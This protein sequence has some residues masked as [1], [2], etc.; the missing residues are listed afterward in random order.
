MKGGQVHRV[1]LTDEMLAIL[2]P[3]RALASDY[4][5]EGQKR[6]HPL[7]NMSMLMLLRRMRQDGVTVHDRYQGKAVIRQNCF[8]GRFEPGAD[9]RFA[10]GNEGATKEHIPSDTTR[11]RKRP[12]LRFS[13]EPHLRPL[14]R[15]DRILM[16]AI[17]R[18]GSFRTWHLLA[19]L[20]AHDPTSTLHPASI[21][22]WRGHINRK[23]D[24]GD[25]HHYQV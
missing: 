3:L 9:L 1:P 10:V 8:D 15:S 24:V 21:R 2:E 4:V 6:H 7:S 25:W 22:Q 12:S 17:P 14:K 11:H 18:P 13:G 20:W 19:A 23:S 16:T 5:F